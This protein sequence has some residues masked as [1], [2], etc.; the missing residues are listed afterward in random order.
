MGESGHTGSSSGAIVLS[1]EASAENT[2]VLVLSTGLGDASGSVYIGSGNT[3]V[4]AGASGSV[5]IGSGNA[6]GGRSGDLYVELGT[7]DTDMGG[8]I[9]MS[10]GKTVEAT[11]TSTGGRVSLLSG[12]STTATSGEI[13]FQTHNSGTAGASGAIVMS[14]G[15]ATHDSGS[16]YI[17]SGFADLGSG[18]VFIGSA[19][20]SG[21][22][23][24]STT[25]TGGTSTSAVGGAISLSAGKSTAANGGDVSI[26][27]GDGH[28][29]SSFS[30]GE[31]TIDT[32]TG[33]NSGS[34]KLRTGSATDSGAGSGNDS[35]YIGLDT[36]VATDGSDSGLIRLRTGSAAQASGAIE[37]LTGS[38][39][40]SG[41]ISLHSGAATSGVSGLLSLSTGDNDGS[42][43]G[44]IHIGSGS[45]TTGTNSPGAVSITVGSR[46]GGGIGS[47]LNLKAGNS[48]SSLLG[49]HVNIYPGSTGE[50]NHGHVKIFPY[51]G[52]TTPTLE[53][54]KDTIQLSDCSV[55]SNHGC[56]DDVKINPSSQF[57]VHAGNNI[58]MKELT[59]NHG[60]TIGSGGNSIGGNLVIE[61]DTTISGKLT[62]VL[63]IDAQQVGITA[64]D[65]R[66]KTDIVRLEGS[67]AKVRKLRGV[68]YNW[69]KK[70]NSPQN[71]DAKRHVGVIAQE[72]KNVLPEVVGEIYDG[73]YLGVDYPALIPLLIEAMHELDDKISVLTSNRKLKSNEDENITVNDRMT[74][75]KFKEMK[76]TLNYKE[77]ILKKIGY[78]SKELE[79]LKLKYAAMQKK[80]I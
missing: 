41:Q 57:Q 71:F 17:A 24:G 23:S 6:A 69:V 10:A 55:A 31:V 56:A 58:V 4:T 29:T 61:D 44:A 52:A 66:L 53:I 25:I 12:E 62:V 78:L 13:L 27:S 34:M 40:T 8:E 18:S 42:G 54:E 26:A 74:R 32:G 15:A 60:I 63:G 65:M 22:R 75:M 43:S 16:V 20:A 48:D 59:N 49:G 2:G 35:G 37:F 28:T 68:Y 11:P 50:S 33:Y 5:K 38:G 73:E 77:D 39:V 80:A 51:V 30:S 70:D 14:T 7:T 67:L 45:M 76:E 19:N 3:N 46:N 64:S 72:V 9:Y 36:G 47:D 1:T 79:D 21:G